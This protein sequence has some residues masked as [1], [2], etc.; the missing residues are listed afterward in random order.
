[1]LRHNL[2]GEL[3]PVSQTTASTVQGK[4]AQSGVVFESQV[5][6]ESLAPTDIVSDLKMRPAAAGFIGNHQKIEKSPIF[7][8]KQTVLD[9]SRSA[10][11]V[12]TSPLPTTIATSIE[13]RL[14]MAA[15]T[16]NH[17]NHRK[18]PIFNQKHPKTL[19]MELFNWENNSESLPTKY[20]PPTKHPCTISGFFFH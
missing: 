4:S 16:E 12:D 9:H 11:D 2:L 14:E 19:V 5:P 13:M 18:P 17:E 3:L 20:I 10:D 8:Q 1:V 6:T 7:A 15:F